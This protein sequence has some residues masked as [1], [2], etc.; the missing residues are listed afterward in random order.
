LT[1]FRFFLA[2]WVVVYHRIDTVGSGSAI[3]WLPGAPDAV[4]AIL[5]SGY[6]AVSVFFVLSGF[7]LAY[8]Y[9]LGR[10]WSKQEHT[11]FAAARFARIYPAYL[12]GILLLVPF[13]WYRVLNG[14]DLSSG[15]YQP[16]ALILNLA[17]VQSWIPSMVL[18]W[19]FPGW[20]LSDEAFFYA[21]FPFLGI[22]LWKLRGS[23][24]LLWTGAT[25]WL[26]ASLP[27]LIAVAIPVQA[28]GDVA[29][30]TTALSPESQPW[31]NL[32]RYQ[33]LL[34]LPEFCAGI[35]LAHLY[36]SWSRSSAL[37]AIRWG[38]WMYRLGGALSLVVLANANR[39]PYPLIHNGLL[40]PAYG[41][42][43]LGLAAGRGLLTKFLSW[44][45]VVFLGNASYSMYILHFPIHA[46]MFSILKRV[47]GYDPQ[48]LW[49]VLLYA[50]SVVIISAVF[51]A[52]VEE[53]LHRS[54]KRRL[55]ARM[56]PRVIG[57]VQSVS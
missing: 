25:I 20:S 56:D 32:I 4:T 45:V 13:G 10:N 18:T 1:G 47:L 51:Y 40:L 37:P 28:F 46:W 6:A 52:F 7:V 17:L 42:V 36:Q 14:M 35:L 53:P 33:P 41:G 50:F 49:W 55:S 12:F 57:P 38:T 16:G 29:A 26:L 5:R 3:P 2:L 31:A 43:I 9:D 39:I 21:C 23:R 19:N 8:N 34:R 11:R 54:I 30:T 22:F 15:G 48:G 27:A 24:A 44:K